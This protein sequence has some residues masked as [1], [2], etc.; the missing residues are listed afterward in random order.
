MDASD[1]GIACLKLHFWRQSDERSTD[2]R[3]RGSVVVDG[4]DVLYRR[5]TDTIIKDTKGISTYSTSNVHFTI[6]R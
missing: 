4:T 3:R 6:V 2:V 1:D 5:A